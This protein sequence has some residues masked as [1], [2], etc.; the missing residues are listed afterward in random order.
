[1]FCNTYII[2]YYQIKGGDFGEDT[3]LCK[4]YEKFFQEYYITQLMVVLHL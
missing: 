2:E 3:I 1:M 4:Y